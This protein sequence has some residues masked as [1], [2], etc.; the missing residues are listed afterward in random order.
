MDAVLQDVHGVGPVLAST[1]IAL[2]PELGKIN[3]KQVT[4]LVGLAPFNRD[5]GRYV[6]K[7]TFWGGRREVRNVLYMA[8]LAA[9]RFNP[10]LKSFYIRL[11]AKGKPKKVALTACMRKLIV[12]LNRKM[13]LHIENTLAQ[14]L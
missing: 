3:D 1:L 4:A 7:R 6:G 9:V 12:A 11:L 8:T 5:S 14:A 13:A 2:L 10:Y